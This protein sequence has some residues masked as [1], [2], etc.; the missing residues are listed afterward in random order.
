MT[1][2]VVIYHGLDNVTNI[3][4]IFTDEGVAETYVELQGQHSEIH[5]YEIEEHELVT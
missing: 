4:G 5:H 3:E 2:W 1:V